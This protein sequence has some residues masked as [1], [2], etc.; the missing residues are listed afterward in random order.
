MTI[1]ITFFSNAMEG[2]EYFVNGEGCGHAHD[3]AEGP[4][5]YFLKGQEGNP[6]GQWWGSGLQHLGLSAGAE[7]TEADARALL[8]RLAHPQEFAR[9]RAAID[10]HVE[11]EGLSDDEAEELYAEAAAKVRLGSKPYAFKSFEERVAARI[12]KERINARLNP[13]RVAEIKREEAEKKQP[14]ARNFLDACFAPSKSSSAYYAGLLAAGRTREAARMVEIHREA[15]GE[16]LEFW[17][18]E[19]GYARA[20]RHGK[21]KDGRASVGRWV[22]AHEWIVGMWDHRTNREGEPH[23]HTHAV[24]LNRVRTVNADGTEKWRALDGRALYAAK[25][26]AAAIYER[27]FEQKME[28]EF[29]VAYALRPDGKAREIIGISEEERAA[30]STRAG[31]VSREVEK[32]AAEYEQRTGRAP[33]AYART[34]MQQDAARTT[35]KRKEATGTDSELLRKWERSVGQTLKT[36]LVAIL[37]RAEA[38][39]IEARGLGDAERFER[40]IVIERAIE[41]VQSQR[42]TWT[43]AHL[44]FAINEVLPDRLGPS[45]LAQRG[46][47]TALLEELADEALSGQYGVVMTQGMELVSAP[48]ELRRA[49]GRSMF[50]PGRDERYSTLDWLADEQRV[51]ER[52]K[53]RGAL[54]LSQVTIADLLEEAAEG[55]RPPSGDQTD[56]VAGVLG[57]AR[58]IDVVVGPAG[59]GKSVAQGLIAKGWE[60]TGRRV[61]GLG[62]SSKAAQ[63]L[64]AQGIRLA[65]NID[66]FLMRLEG[67][68]PRH[69]V[70]AFQIRHGDM[71][72]VDEAGM[73]STEHLVRIAKLVEAA[74]GKLVLCGDDA[75][76]AAVEAGGLF[77]EL[78]RLPQ[79]LQLGT[80]R[81]FRDADG[82]PRTWEAK[83]SLGLREGQ[84]HALDAYMRRG[85]IRSGTVEEMAAEIRQAYVTDRLR[86]V[87]SVIMTAT[88]AQAVELSASIRAELAA[89]GQVEADGVELADGTRAGRGDLIQARRNVNKL[90][91]SAGMPVYNRYVYRVAE[92][93]ED[94]ALTVERVTGS[95]EVG[96]RVKLPARYVAQHVT[97]GYAGTVHSVQG[98]TVQ[99]GYELVTSATTREQLY[100]GMTRGW[101]ENR[102]FVGLEPEES[103]LEVLAEVLA[104]VG[105]ERSA[106]EVMRSD[107]EWA[108]T[109]GAHAPIWEELVSDHQRAK[110]SEIL[111]QALGEPLYER[112]QAEDPSTVYRQVWAAEMAGH[113]PQAL[114][115]AAVGS[116]GKGLDDAK[117]VP[118]L[119]HWRIER[120][121][122]VR[123]PEREAAGASWTARTPADLTGPVGDYVRELAE[124][125][126]ARTQALGEQAVTEPPAWAVERLG[127]VPA[128]PIERADWQQRAAVVEA[129]REQY[130]VDAP[131]T[132]IGPPP[133]RS[134]VTQYAAWEAAHTALG[135]SAEEQRLAEASTG[136][137]REQVEI[138]E[139][140]QEWAPPSVAEEM[141]R[142]DEQRRA[143]EQEAAL[144]Q[145]QAAL[146]VD[147]AQR[148]QLQERAA[149]AIEQ[150]QQLVGL[151]AAI[152]QRN[153]ERES[154]YERTSAL[155]EQ[156]EAALAELLRRKADMPEPD[157][158]PEVERERQ[159][160]PEQAPGIEREP[161]Q[162]QREAEV[163]RQLAE[164]WDGKTTPEIEQQWQEE[165]AAERE[166]QAQAEPS[167]QQ[168]EQEAFRQLIERWDARDAARA[169][170]EANRERQAER[171]QAPEVEQERQAEQPGPER[172]QAPE[173]ERTPD[174]LRPQISARVLEELREAQERALQPEQASARER[175]ERGAEVGQ[176]AERTPT[177]REQI[178]A[179]LSERRE[180]QERR[181]QE[182]A[183]ERE[184]APEVERSPQEITREHHYQ[185]QRE[186]EQTMV[187]AAERS[188]PAVEAPTVQAPTIQAPQGP[189]LGR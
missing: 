148:V 62:P 40:R 46:Y 86:G 125:M 132:V 94:G 13:E 150:A 160:E 51:I 167:Q 175:T 134:M 60:A 11:A 29:P 104:N 116:R 128:D 73:A 77:R 177:L 127:P 38:A 4:E 68:G 15:V 21:A 70:E 41:R 184:Q 79:A 157:Q 147:Q 173:A 143:A 111:R 165:R 130:Q 144:A 45:V 152:E 112:L 43:R 174:D 140:E 145:A 54:A 110:H 66:K 55:G 99:V 179:R 120:E 56:V 109:I 139:R 34:I 155:R 9:A 33:S 93:H 126:D 8:G 151:G 164:R 154:W 10:A 36:T 69:E 102:A 124:V 156:A 119:L 20:G 22:D 92:R 170:Q 6:V 172:E 81:R 47:T 57:D 159:A 107:L 163:F 182:R 65:A 158:A 122:T 16:A 59:A 129:Y 176:E 96:G 83:A 169:E 25:D 142:V 42:S 89:L 161:S 32:W 30:L 185:Q 180:A 58:P 189:T 90:V 103:A 44:M 17:Q 98:D 141:A 28:A 181:E 26:A 178:E 27:A 39:A 138:W 75:Q 1:N 118:A 64:Q 37:E 114:V 117:N 84:V 67:K 74:G 18:R 85:R 100:V 186:A 133:G 49:D 137:L 23:L 53:K 35:R 78:A 71:V 76:L 153:T 5:Q 72:I 2:V 101:M 149:Q 50:R 7:I 135:R 80:V 31:Q 48:Q 52:A 95:E 97:L 168:R 162:Q 91:D 171:E 105:V 187:L 131:S 14:K 166:R 108:E 113:D 121:L 188:A 88:E 12:K 24:I 61:I 87:E 115:S 106:S 146:E 63:V 136:T 82:T 19:A 183:A 3:H 123:T